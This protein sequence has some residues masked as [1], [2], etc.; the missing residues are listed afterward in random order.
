MWLVVDAP[1]GGAPDEVDV[2][3]LGELMVAWGF[4]HSRILGWL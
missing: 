1:D 4:I 3:R 2:E